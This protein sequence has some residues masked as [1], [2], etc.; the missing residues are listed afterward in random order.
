[1]YFHQDNSPT[2]SREGFAIQVS[3][4]L[5]LADPG[6]CSF[7]GLPEGTS[8]MPRHVR[9][10]VDFMTRAQPAAVCIGLADN[11]INHDTVMEPLENLM[12]IGCLA[13]LPRNS[14][15]EIEIEFP[16]VKSADGK[17]TFRPLKVRVLLGDGN[18]SIG[19][20][21]YF[22]MR[23]HRNASGSNKMSQIY[24]STE[25]YMDFK[26]M[27]TA[28]SFQLEHLLIA[29]LEGHLKHKD[30]QQFATPLTL[31]GL[32]PDSEIVDEGGIGTWLST[33]MM[34]SGEGKMSVELLHQQKVFLNII[35]M[36]RAMLKFSATTET[37]LT[38]LQDRFD[39]TLTA[40]LCC[41]DL[42]GSWKDKCKSN[43][44]IGKDMLFNYFDALFTVDIVPYA[45]EEFVWVRYCLCT[46]FACCSLPAEQVTTAVRRR[47]EAACTTYYALVL[48]LISFGIYTEEEMVNLYFI[49]V[50]V[51]IAR[52]FGSDGCMILREAIAQVQEQFWKSLRE[53]A[54]RF[55]ARGGGHYK[56]KEQGAQPIGEDG[57]S[58]DG[59]DNTNSTGNT[60]KKSRPVWQP[61][62]VTREIMG[63]HDVRQL[64]NCE[65]GSTGGGAGASSVA[66]INERCG[67]RWLADNDILDTDWV[68]PAC[69]FES[70]RCMAREWETV[71]KVMGWQASTYNTDESGDLI[72]ACSDSSSPGQKPTL[73]T[74]TVCAGVRETDTLVVEP[75]GQKHAVYWRGLRVIRRTGLG[76][77]V[78][79]SEVHLPQRHLRASGTIAENAVRKYCG[80]FYRSEAEGGV[81]AQKPA[82]IGQLKADGW[83]QELFRLVDAH[84]WDA[85]AEAADVELERIG[86]SAAE[87]WPPALQG[88]IA[89]EAIVLDEPE[90]NEPAHRDAAAANPADVRA[91]EQS[92]EGEI[93][94]AILAAQQMGL[95]RAT[96]SGRRY[97]PAPPWHRIKLLLTV[98]VTTTLLTVTRHRHTAS[99]PR[100]MPSACPPTPDH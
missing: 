6:V 47:V 51:V 75:H 90:P 98:T 13:T 64:W 79:Q 84:T 29:T 27:L 32:A 41:E 43:M 80:Y 42:G 100:P 9:R 53:T 59:A 45:R 24:A 48:D 3:L 15:G 82:S 88:H 71:V 56:N 16:Q 57:G 72:I 54:R 92:A 87:G 4:A 12:R 33:L 73:P 25:Q 23:S 85:I 61:E 35:Y 11:R 17:F 19:D 31:F 44:A 91:T 37:S 7:L 36:Y 55:T 5:R 78:L 10:A 86:G 60:S 58:T 22:S 1:M 66:G 95:G 26:A 83:R 49:Q 96:R 2:M 69:M 62:P 18:G 20:G 52:A 40:W 38:T 76:G 93:Y 74:M 34:Q 89:G 46:I 8:R 30:V 81:A 63:R 65:H 94:R 77:T 21:K 28:E 97:V 67:P 68:I 70:G 99:L 14:D 50:G 39:A